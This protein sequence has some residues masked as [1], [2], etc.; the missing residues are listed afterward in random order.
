MCVC[1]AVFCKKRHLHILYAGD[2][3]KILAFG[4]K[5]KFY[6]IAKFFLKEC[7]DILLT[8]KKP[9]AIAVIVLAVLVI[10]I[11]I[12]MVTQNKA[13]QPILE[14]AERYWTLLENGKYND[15]IKMLY[16]KPECEHYRQLTLDTYPKQRVTDFK[17]TNI[18][19]V[20]DRLYEI[21][22]ELD[23]FGW[24][25]KEITTNY[26][27]YIDQAWA[28]I[29]NCEDVPD[30]IHKYDNDDDDHIIF[31]SPYQE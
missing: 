29:L 23:I 12:F 5:S 13:K 26:V 28:Y 25:K 21:D 14:L 24:K 11:S 17:I 7:G 4:R 18:T 30:S 27:A 22:M 2:K 31:D 6:E 8:K 16:F 20:N 3:N 9:I 19:K 15:A 10:A 1:K